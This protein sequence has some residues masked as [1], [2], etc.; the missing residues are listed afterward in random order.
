MKKGRHFIPFMAFLISM[1]A[2]GTCIAYESGSTTAISR[3]LDSSHLSPVVRLA[4]WNDFFSGIK[5][6]DG[7]TNDFELDFGL[8]V[9]KE[10]FTL[11]AVHR[12][13]TERGGLERW[14]EAG[15]VLSWRHHFDFQGFMLVVR[16]HLGL[17]VGGNLGG[18][19]IQEWFHSLPMI[20][21]RKPGSGLQDIY[22]GG[23]LYG[24][25][26]GGELSIEAALS[27][28]FKIRGGFD[29]QG[30]PLATG[31]SWVTLFTGAHA[32]FKYSIIRP[33]AE[34]MLG[35]SIYATNDMNLTMPGGYRTGTPQFMADVIVGLGIKDWS[36]GWNFRYNDGG[37]GQA[38][39]A[40]FVEY[41][42]WS[43]FE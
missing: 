12:M 24:F 38:I 16:P 41:G 10:Y 23:T 18:M 35:E 1:T 30:A 26:A 31:M 19:R 6:D 5:D 28:I 13:L 4:W 20:S 36:L 7:F 21:G 27:K 8:H 11:E 37:N 9:G 40:I 15:A 29:C 33:Y 17:A 22:N 39:A 32:E 25:T 3:N 42:G 14:D 2:G 43:R 34:V